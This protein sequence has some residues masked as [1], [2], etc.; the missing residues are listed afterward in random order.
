MKHEN[1]L[2]G[3]IRDSWR[4]GAVFR[5]ARVSLMHVVSSQRFVL[6]P[7][8][9]SHLIDEWQLTDSSQLARSGFHA[10]RVLPDPASW[11]NVDFGFV[12]VAFGGLC[13]SLCLLNHWN[14]AKSPD[15]VGCV[16]Y[17]VECRFDEACLQPASLEEVLIQSNAISTQALQIQVY[18]SNSFRAEML[19]MRAS[20]GTVV[21]Q[22][23]LAKGKDWLGQVGWLQ[24]VNM[25]DQWER[26]SMAQDNEFKIET[27]LRLPVARSTLETESLELAA[28]DGR[29]GNKSFSHGKWIWS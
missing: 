8:I 14:C 25:W 13:E 12:C 2:P 4:S 1:H 26:M 24:C 21:K 16:N 22:T 6:I 17:L 23:P 19:A 29:G 5:L 20:I 11:C 7:L 10:L 15:E 18:A 28:V 27:I 3:A 9:D